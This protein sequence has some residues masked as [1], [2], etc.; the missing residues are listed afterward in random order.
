MFS[1]SWKQ[2]IQKTCSWSCIRLQILKIRWRTFVSLFLLHSL[3]TI[4]LNYIPSHSPSTNP[5][6]SHHHPSPIAKA[7]FQLP[8]LPPAGVHVLICL[9]ENMQ[10]I[11]TFSQRNF[12]RHFGIYSPTVET[13]SQLSF[14][15]PSGHPAMFYSLKFPS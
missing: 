12:Q 9:W 14:T 6:S 4:F 13:F 5:V 10:S 7:L 3:F 2:G 15:D 8:L 11:P 1:L